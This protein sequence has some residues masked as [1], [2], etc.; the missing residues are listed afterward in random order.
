[1]WYRQIQACSLL[2]VAEAV[3]H[4]I[5]SSLGVRKCRGSQVLKDTDI[6]ASSW[7]DEMI[8]VCTC[9]IIKKRECKMMPHLDITASSSDN[10][11]GVQ[12]IQHST[13]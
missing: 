4:V 6:M 12:L 1:M 2:S 11:W 5:E 13:L 10:L 8:K 3:W 9:L 7:P